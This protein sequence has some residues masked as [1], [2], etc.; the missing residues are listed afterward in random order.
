MEIQ[1]PH[2]V[3]LKASAGSGKT[4]AL[5]ERFVYFLLSNKVPYNSLRNILA[6][7]FS[8]NAA[9]EM[10]SRIMQWLKNIYFQE[11]SSISRFSELTGLSNEELSFRAGEVLDE[12][13]NHYSDF[14][15][16][17]IDSFMT[18]IFKASALDFDYNPEFEI[19]MNNESL[20][21]LSYDL[22]LKDVEENSIKTEFLNEIIEIINS[23]SNTYVWN[24]SERIFNEIKGLHLKINNTD[25]EFVFN[26]E[27]R[28]ILKNI[29]VK[30]EE[31]IENIKKYIKSSG[32]EINRSTKI[33]DEFDRII[34]SRNF[35]V[36]LTKGIKRIP[37]NKP[38]D[39]SLSQKYE[40]ILI[41]WNRFVDV[42]KDYALYY[43]LTFYLPYLEVYQSFKTLLNKIKQKECKI[44]IEDINKILSE[45]LN[46]SIV[47]DIYF[48]LGEKIH[49]FFIDEY[50]DTSPLQW[51]NLKFLIENALAESGSLFVVGD[52]KQA[53]YTFR[54]ADYRIMKSLE[55]ME[56]FPSAAKAVKTLDKNYRSRKKIIDFVTEIFMNKVLKHSA[57][58]EAGKFAGFNECQQITKESN[59]EGYVEVK[60]FVEDEETEIKQ[61]LAE[62]IRDITQRGY[63]LRD[64][65]I[66]AFK[67]E[68]V[69]TISQWL[70]ELNMP[71]ISYSSL[72][73]RK[74]K[75]TSEILSLL[76]FLDSPIDDF[77]FSVFLLGDI[78]KRIIKRDGEK[79]SAEEFLIK[80][81]DETTLYK[82]FERDFPQLWEKYFRQLFKLSGYLPIYDLVSVALDNFK[83]FETMPE[84]EATFIKL[85]DLV[86]QFE[87]NGYN[88][89]KDL[90]DFF[91]TPTDDTIWNITTPTEINAIQVMTIHK[92]KGL[93]FPI[94]FVYLENNNKPK[95]R[96]VLHEDDRG[97]NVL[98][99]TNQIAEKNELLLKI[100]DEEK[101]SEIIDL[102][103]TLYVA[104]T[105]AEDELYVLCRTDK[106][107]KLPFDILSEYYGSEIGTKSYKD[108][109][110]SLLEHSELT[111]SHY[112][113][114]LDLAIS[115]EIIHF[116]E[117]KRGDFIHMLLA[118]IEYLEENF[119]ENID[120][121]IDILNKHLHTNFLSSEIK[122]LIIDMI[123]HPEIGKFFKQRYEKIFN[124]MEV[125]DK[126]GI[127]HRIDRVVIDKDSVTV[128]EYKTG[129]Q[130]QEH[131]SQ[132]KLY[133]NL[134]SDIFKDK[135]VEGYLYYLDLREVKRVD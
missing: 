56:I 95:N 14:Q 97:V 8:N 100:K 4:T 10:K 96:Y 120:A 47:P 94:V 90:I 44:F 86:K 1:F 130:Q 51:N 25:K 77:S 106:E 85:L 37:V 12:I 80:Y 98:K 87:E 65:S 129:S 131:L 101:K 124:E 68:H 33:L 62:C 91:E 17:T 99:I 78:F 128:I 110:L 32:L 61:Y 29:E 134:I 116:N 26:K 132:I 57:Y 121:L 74:R 75:V 45:Y 103:N 3:I 18:S 104:F 50:Q 52:T 19:L 122:P 66:L 15:V 23:N 46:N 93:G 108:K 27:Y 9:F 7:T 67:N 79:F 60:N 34:E 105:R 43:A 58:A 133:M 13:L 49:H 64:I 115:D 24:P 36:L 59:M 88:S 125:I 69:I 30:L 16:K 123:D 83:V 117:K 63:Q 126:E 11:E 70:N 92:A 118:Q 112:P 53:I 6:I 111:A 73:V 35:K 114:L 20:F 39:Q 54:G 84:E 48:R 40:N 2:Y 119:L 107:D 76:R 89:I 71:F 109:P 72:D 31:T 55:E 113:L 42:L 102:L 41:L 28:E 38:K 81:R 22:F 21:R 82:H 135:R 5:T 127:L